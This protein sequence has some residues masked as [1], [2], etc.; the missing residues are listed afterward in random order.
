MTPS[1]QTNTD[2]TV[3]CVNS[4]KVEVSNW[5]A[6]SWM[7]KK[8]TAIAIAGAVALLTYAGTGTGGNV[9]IPTPLPPSSDTMLNQDIFLSSSN[10]EG[11]TGG[12]KDK[13]HILDSGC[14]TDIVGSDTTTISYDITS[15][16]CLS[17]ITYNDN[18]I[19]FHADHKKSAS[20]VKSFK[21]ENNISGNNIVSVYTD[22]NGFPDELNYWISMKLSL[23][24]LNGYIDDFVLA[25]GSNAYIWGGGNNYYVGGPSCAYYP[26]KEVGKSFCCTMTN[27]KLVQLFVRC[28]DNAIRIHNGCDG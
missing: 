27:G 25:Q 15:K 20:V 11:C 6:P 18:L 3:P 8:I 13:F 23:P 4:S 2:T 10:T 28:Y 22:I 7:N 16:K 21:S 14:T 1:Y 9:S 12:H 19:T 17:G 26:R 5:A 24:T